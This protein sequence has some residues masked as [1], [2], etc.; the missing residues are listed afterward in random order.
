MAEFSYASDIAPLRSTFFP[1][2]G[3]SRLQRQQLDTRYAKDIEPIDAKRREIEKDMLK[4]IESED[5]FE[6]QKLQLEEAKRTAQMRADT[7]TRLPA[8]MTELD[9]VLGNKGI[10]TNTK[11]MEV[12]KLNMRYSN[13][14][15]Y[16]PSVATLLSGANRQVASMQSIDEDKKRQSA[17]DEQKRLSIISSA[18]QIGDTALVKKLTDPTTRDTVDLNEAYQT[19]G[20]RSQEAKDLDKAI[21]KQKVQYEQTEN[22]RKSQLSMLQ[23]FETS[24]RSM[25]RAK[26][27][28]Y[29]VPSTTAERTAEQIAQDARDESQRAATLTL[30]ETE[31]LRLKQMWTVLNP[32]EKPENAPTKDNE[33]YGA[34]SNR[35]YAGIFSNSLSPPPPKSREEA[36]FEAPPTR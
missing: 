11:A 23:N 29:E 24:I 26:G 14:A 5:A 7:D 35:V 3:M 4:M 20:Q 32:K 17:L 1:A 2:S 25:G 8:L 16:N 18:I 30:A 33:L 34:V 36:A 10:D 21:A 19:L 15:T 13:L 27:D 22:V 28:G 31:R 12:G 6:M 9:S